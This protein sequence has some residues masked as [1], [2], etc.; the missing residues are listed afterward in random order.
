MDETEGYSLDGD[1]SPLKQNTI[2]ARR[3]HPIFSSFHDG[4]LHCRKPVL[5]TSFRQFSF[6]R[7]ETT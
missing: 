5:R 7:L 1:A 4:Q 6:L 2:T 3:M